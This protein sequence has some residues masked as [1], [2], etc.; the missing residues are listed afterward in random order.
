MATFERLLNT[1]DRVWRDNLDANGSD[2][3][4]M[5]WRPVAKS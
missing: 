5:K 4:S 1:F 3:Q 2:N